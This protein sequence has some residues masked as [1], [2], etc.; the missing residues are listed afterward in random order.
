MRSTNITTACSEFYFKFLLFWCFIFTQILKKTTVLNVTVTSKTIKLKKSVN[1]T[2][3]EKRD[4]KLPLFEL[5]QN[6]DL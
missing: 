4:M 5:L 6:L 3:S 1:R 2:E